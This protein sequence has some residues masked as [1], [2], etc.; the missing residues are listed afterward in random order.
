VDV[1]HGCQWVF[2]HMSRLTRNPLFTAVLV[3]GDC[4]QGQRSEWEY[5]FAAGGLNLTFQIA[6]VLGVHNN[7]GQLPK[8]AAGK[9]AA[10][11]LV[12]H[13]CSHTS[14]ATLHQPVRTVLVSQPLETPEL[15]QK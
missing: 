14:A 8:T 13:Q 10:T 6:E 4:L 11:C 1:Q 7:P 9:L 12:P 3:V 5:P 2:S 15:V